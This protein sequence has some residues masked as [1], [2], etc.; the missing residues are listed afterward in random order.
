MKRALFIGRF[1]PFH[2]GHLSV[3]HQAK[4]LGWDEVIIGIGSSQYS[5]QDINPFTYE[6][7]VKIIQASTQNDLELPKLYIM[8]LPDIHDDAK[9]VEHV[10]TIIKNN[11]LNYDIVFSGNANVYS[12]FEKASIPVKTLQQTID[13][14]STTIRNYIRTNNP[15]WK[16]FIHPGAQPFVATQPSLIDQGSE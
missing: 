7:R 1:Q 15:E 6:Q 5:D 12:L 8:S 4:Q 10:D 2:L 14:N 13:I 9:W 16:T 11:N 3:L